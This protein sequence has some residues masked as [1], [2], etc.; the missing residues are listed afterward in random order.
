MTTFLLL[1]LEILGYK[2]AIQYKN[3]RENKDGEEK[4]EDL[5]MYKMI[6][7]TSRW[8]LCKQ[9]CNVIT[10]M[11]LTRKS[12]KSSPKE[13]CHKNLLGLGGFG[14]VYKVNFREIIY[15]SNKNFPMMEMFLLSSWKW[16]YYTIIWVREVHMFP[17]SFVQ[18]SIKE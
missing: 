11:T 3:P 16:H 6:Q 10:W 7:T 2:S 14:Q 5:Y 12:L 18:T 13:F 4:E 9:H 17:R 8:I 1:F 15:Y